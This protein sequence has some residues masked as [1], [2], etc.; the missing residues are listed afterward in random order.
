MSGD[1][2]FILSRSNWGDRERTTAKFQCVSCPETTEVPVRSGVP[3]DPEGYAKRVNTAGWQAHPFRRAKTYCPACL[4]PAAK[5]DPD[6]ELRKVVPMA[7][8]PTTPATTLPL[9]PR[10]VDVA[11]PTT[12]QRHAVRQHLDKS[13]DDNA[14]CYLDGLSDQRVAELVGVPRIIVEQMREAAYGP[15][16]LDPVVAGLRAEVAQAKRELDGQ[17]KTLDALKTKVAEMSSRLEKMTGG[18]AA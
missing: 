14:G 10:L 1:L 11:A 12:M 13:F 18:K 3:L 9:P 16:K 7:I 2:G 5:N 4:M 17:Q 8:P 6:S 15:I